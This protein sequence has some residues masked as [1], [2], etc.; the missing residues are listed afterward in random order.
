MSGII[1]DMYDLRKFAEIV[2]IDSHLEGGGSFFFK[3]FN[4]FFN[5]KSFIE[6]V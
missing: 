1:D 5:R 6:K 4:K 2:H 3:K